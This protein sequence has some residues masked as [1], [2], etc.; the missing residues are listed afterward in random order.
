M[1][2][3][4]CLLGLFSVE[5]KAYEA[6]VPAFHVYTTSKYQVWNS[7]TYV[8]GATTWY[9]HSSTI[10]ASHVKTITHGSGKLYATISVEH[11]LASDNHLPLITG[12]TNTEVSIANIAF[13]AFVEDDRGF[14]QYF[15]FPD[16]VAV[17]LVG[18]SGTV[19]YHE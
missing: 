18:A 9:P 4:A 15:Y 10:P 3:C 6:D 1:L 11:V 19:Y 13:E 7:T 17:Q 5:T 16:L 8:L 14:R 2:C 12:D